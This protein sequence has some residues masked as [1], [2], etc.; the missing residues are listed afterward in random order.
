MFVKERLKQVKEKGMLNLKDDSMNQ[1]DLD[2]ID[3]YLVF[4]SRR[5]SNLK[6]NRNPLMSKSIQRNR[7]DSQQNKSFDDKYKF[8]CFNCGIVGH[9]SNECRKPKNEK[10]RNA[11]D[12]IDYR[13]KYVDLL[14]SKKKAFVSE[15]KDWAAAG[16]DSDEEEFINFAFIAKS[17]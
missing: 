4:L 13:K 11:S 14:I 15:E 5:F 8:K 12:V 17:K 1:E 2:D 3:E 6:F 10:K 16:E 7:I 9:F